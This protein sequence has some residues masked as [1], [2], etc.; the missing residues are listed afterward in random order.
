MEL[1]KTHKNHKIDEN[2]NKSNCVGP[3][4]G[5]PFDEKCHKCCDKRD[6]KKEEKNTVYWIDNKV[7]LFSLRGSNSEWESESNE[8]V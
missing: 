6:S 4:H 1:G 5:E 7:N 3:S 8:Q 2:E